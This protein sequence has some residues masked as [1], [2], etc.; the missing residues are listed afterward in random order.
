VGWGYAAYLAVVFA[1]LSD[2]VFNAGRVCV[3]L[4][5]RCIDSGGSVLASC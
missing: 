3:F 5:N 1:F 2:I 4:M